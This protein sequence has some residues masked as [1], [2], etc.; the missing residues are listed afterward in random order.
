MAMIA[1]RVGA[2]RFTYHAPTKVFSAEM[3]DF[4]RA[5]PGGRVY[6]DACDFGFIMVN[7]R[8]GGEVLFLLAGDKRDGEGDCLWETYIGYDLKGR[9]LT[10]RLA[11]IEAR[12][13]ND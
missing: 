3:S 8:T 12:L 9:P 4:A 13:Y 7:P 1:P 10:G 2:E 6:D 5:G 11:G